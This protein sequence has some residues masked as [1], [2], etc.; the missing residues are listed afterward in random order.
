MLL[1]NA[2]IIDS[3][4]G[5]LLSGRR[6]I[7]VRNGLIQEVS[8]EPILAPDCNSINLNGLFVCPLVSK[9]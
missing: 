9:K 3:A 5:R 2:S 4:A 6:S 7:L 8:E 1:T